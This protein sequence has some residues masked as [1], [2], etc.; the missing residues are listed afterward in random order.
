MKILAILI[1][2]L[3]AFATGARA[4][5][6]EIHSPDPKIDQRIELTKID[7]ITIDKCDTNIYDL[8]GCDLDIDSVK[9]DVQC[10]TV[11][12][13]AYFSGSPS[14]IK[15]TIYDVEG[16]VI[17]TSIG[18]SN[19]S[20]ILPTY[21]S[22]YG[23]LEASC[24]GGDDND[25]DE[26][27]D[28]FEIDY[29]LPTAEF[30][31][32]EHVTQISNVYVLELYPANTSS[33]SAVSFLWT[34]KD[35]ATNA[36]VATSTLETPVFSGLD[37]NKNYNVELAA[38]DVRGCSNTS[39]VARIASVDC[40]AE[41]DFK[42]T[43]C[44]DLPG[45]DSVKVKFDN[46]STFPVS[47]SQVVSYEWD[48]GDGSP[49]SAQEEPEHIFECNDSS[50]TF[51]VLL[52]LVV[53][54]ETSPGIWED[55]TSSFAFNVTLELYEPYFTI[56]KCCDGR[57][58]FCTD[59]VKGEWSTP[60]AMDMCNAS[61]C[62]KIRHIPGRDCGLQSERGLC[63]QT[64]WRYYE[65]PGTYD[66]TFYG[67]SG[68]GNSCPATREFWLG[69]V[70]CFN[71]NAPPQV[72]TVS[73]DGYD[74]KMKFKVVQWPFTHKIIAKIKAKGKKKMSQISARFDGTLHRLGSDG[75]F[76]DTT[77]VNINP[78]TRFNKRRA[79]AKLNHTGRFRVG[80]DE[81]TAT[82]HVET[83]NGQ[84]TTWTLKLGKPPCDRPCILW[85]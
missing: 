79:K 59:Q 62:R 35:A 11:S 51:T 58:V 3:I 57:V 40:H 70:K 74:F 64:Y 48:F 42:Y 61:T 6:L 13:T 54:T 1:G 20:F 44:E 50:E 84:T 85:Y 26:D 78:G 22:Y 53:S 66:V 82:Y 2:A 71:R 12:C 77:T 15:W 81:L 65:N 83:P 34:V 5:V 36:T 47:S 21:G 41:F 49:L 46:L 30:T 9:V 18:S 39:Q 4:Q 31:L 69:E 19:I 38:T 17:L 25:G 73:F 67:T 24:G 55:C 43:W 68:H 37:P 27:E 45:P 29:N 14:Y 28:A 32:T 52:T 8:E 63:G 10:G 56:T 7:S 23:T 33:A 76:C 75:C 80:M 72:S 16:N 60:E